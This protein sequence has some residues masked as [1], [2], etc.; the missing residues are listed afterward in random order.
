VFGDSAVTAP[1][2]NR[3]I[4]TAEVINASGAQN[5]PGRYAHS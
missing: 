1:A 4:H 3:L 5:Y 2:I